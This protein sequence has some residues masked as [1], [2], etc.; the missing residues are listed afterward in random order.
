M[1]RR[2]RGEYTFKVDAKGRV[3]IPAA[4]RRVLE[5]GDPAYTDG[6]RPQFVIV[7]GPASQTY[8]ECY[9]INETQAL[10]DKIN[11]L[12]N[13]PLKR[14]LVK[15]K[16]TQSHD[17]EVDPDGRLVL[18]ARLRDKIG[19]GKEAVFQGTLTT[20]R[21]WS[22]EAYERHMTEDNEDLGFDIP[23]GTDLL[24]A[25]DMALDRQGGG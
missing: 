1:G 14:R 15:E 3:S 23:E 8:L 4:F 19:L 5:S 22:A 9:T 12:P 6:L 17:S 16:I 20:F 7:Y 10:E 2:F 18:P 11:Q 24:D 21:I 25:L 13:S